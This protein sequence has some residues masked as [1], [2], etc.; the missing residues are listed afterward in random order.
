[1][2]SADVFDRYHRSIET[3]ANQ[4]AT[5]VVDMLRRA[6]RQSPA[7]SVGARR[8]AL[9]TMVTEAA[10]AIARRY[11]LASAEVAAALWEDIYFSDT[12]SRLEALIADLDDADY[13]GEAATTIVQGRALSEGIEG[14]ERAIASF[15]H[16][17][18]MDFARQTMIGNTRRVA[19]SRRRGH[20][21]ARWIRVP[22]GDKTCAWCMM[23]ASRGPVYYTRDTAGGDEHHGTEMDRFHSYCDCEIVAAFGDSPELDGYSWQEYEAMYR[24]ALA[25]KPGR[26]KAEIVDINTTLANMRR[27]Y[28]LK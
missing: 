6:W 4:S 15:A 10:P 1:M 21:R 13:F 19:R 26:T 5:E 7:T 14:A 9:R 25:Y 20:D 2:L 24:D 3:I 18:V 17:M 12:G 27:M 28:G 22:T 11:G 8:E 23:L 16:A